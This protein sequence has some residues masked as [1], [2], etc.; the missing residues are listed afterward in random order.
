VPDH[1][2]EDEEVDDF[3]GQNRA[4]LVMLAV[5]LGVP[6]TAVAV[7]PSFRGLGELPGGI[8]SSLGRAVSPD[9]SVVVGTSFSSGGAEAFRWEEGVMTGLGDLSGGSFSS[10]GA[11]VSA[12]GRVVVGRATSALGN[13]AFV[14]TSNDAM[15]PLRLDPDV[16]ITY[17]A[18]GITPDGSVIVGLAPGGEAFRFADGTF[19]LLGDLPGS[20]EYSEA[21]GVSPDGATIVGKGNADEGS[22]EAF[23]WSDG[24]MESLGDLPGGWF[25]SEAWDLSADS[26]VIVGFG[27]GEQ[28]VEAVR[29]DRTGTANGGELIITPLGDLPGGN[30]YSEAH[31]VSADGSVIVGQSDTDEGIRAFLWTAE[32]GMR[33]LSDVLQDDF[34]LDVSGWLI[35]EANGI[36]ADGLTIVGTGYE[37]GVGRRG[38]IAT[39]P[40]PSTVVMIIVGTMLLACRR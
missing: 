27:S 16:R 28:G 25:N 38:W 15:Q 35:E 10:G 9:G 22:A 33:S 7:E 6:G 2:Q 31:A 19:T 40:E 36:S 3:A 29:W 26:S 21:L 32:R 4:W 23:I 39:L 5:F 37:L 20:P 13:E 1:Q 12:F 8:N 11:A 34:G 14:W 30:H 17:S 24:V 18:T